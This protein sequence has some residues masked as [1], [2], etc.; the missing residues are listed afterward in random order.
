GTRRGTHY[1]IQD[2]IHM[3]RDFCETLLEYFDPQPN[4]EKLRNKLW[5]RLIKKGS[6]A[7][8]PANIGFSDTNS[9]SDDSDRPAIPVRLRKKKTT[10]SARQKKENRGSVLQIVE[11]V[12]STLKMDKSERRTKFLNKGSSISTS[13]GGLNRTDSASGSGN[14]EREVYDLSVGEGEVQRAA[15]DGITK[16][17]MERMGELMSSHLY[18]SDNEGDGGPL[19]NFWDIDTS[20]A[21]SA[22]YSSSDELLVSARGSHVRGHPLEPVVAKTRLHLPPQ[23]NNNQKPTRPSHSLYSSVR[24]RQV[25]HKTSTI[26]RRTHISRKK[27][28]HYAQTSHNPKIKK[29]YK[30]AENNHLSIQDGQNNRDELKSKKKSPRFLSPNPGSEICET[31]YEFGNNFLSPNGY[32]YSSSPSHL[33]MGPCEDLQVSGE[34]VVIRLPVPQLHKPN[35]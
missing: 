20:F 16:S 6:S 5:S 29:L 11:K 25:I 7:D 26:A 27:E 17:Y 15:M 2:F 28:R 19:S 3:G 34:E 31:I 30:D 32:Q 35:Q 14:R 4:K 21:Q 23:H 18:V 8:E 1:N 24:T 10:K 22:K 13:V 9:S 33:D 12:T